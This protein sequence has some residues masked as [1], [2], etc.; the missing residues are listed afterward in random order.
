[1]VDTFDSYSAYD[2]PKAK[3]IQFV[4]KID[5]KFYFSNK[6]LL[7]VLVKKRILLAKKKHDEHFLDNLRNPGK[8]SHLLENEL[9][10]IFPSR[11]QWIRLNKRERRGKS[12]L[13]INAVSL[14]RTV[15]RKTRNFKEA[16][17]EDWYLKLIDFISEVRHMAMSNDYEIPEPKVVP[18][19]KKM[20]GEKKIYRPIAV[21]D[22][23]NKILISQ[24]NKY[25]TCCFD[26]VF[27]ENSYAFR[28]IKKGN[29]SYTHHL[30]VAD[31]IDYKRSNSNSEIWVS[32]CD[33]KKFYDVINHGIILKTLDE[34][35]ERCKK[36]N[37]HIENRPLSLLESYLNSYS[38]N[39]KVLKIKLPLN[40]EFGWV[41]ENELKDVDSNIYTDNIGIPQGG[42]FS[43]LI[44]NLIMDVVDRDVI[45]SGDQDLF[46][47]RF[48]DDMVI[49]HP[50]KEK[51]EAVLESYLHGLKK[52][53]LIG[54]PPVQIDKYSKQFWL[55][56]SKSPY[57][58]S[59]RANPK[60]VPWLSFV[61]YQISHN[62][63]IRVR[64]DSISKELRKQADEIGKVISLLNSRKSIKVSKSALKFRIKQ[65]LLTMS[66][67]RK[68][69]FNP[70]KP[71]VMCWTAGFK[72]LKV[73]NN[74][75]FQL[76]YL[77]RKRSSHFA[78][79]DRAIEIAPTSRFPKNKK[80][81]K[82]LENEPKFYGPPY[83]Y[84]YQ[85]KHYDR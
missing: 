22:L 10:E 71:G 27:C 79:L 21:F 68:S 43:C 14:E 5:F 32:E 3:G 28:S 25:L 37:I 42:A 65:R 23:K 83:S 48:C 8:D 16:I 54:H 38:F 75:D 40:S 46:Y 69:I 19:F 11:N 20:D 81:P 1:M 17:E 12:A 50:S 64:R 34:Q 4:M 67:G 72:I 26:Q 35:V 24:T 73:E 60:N 44:A 77:D 70:Q 9:Y 47:A 56:K 45:S 57:L 66:V 33:I 55:S 29:S 49:L 63:D 18:L 13:E 59:N 15:I 6:A 78:R 74:L 53:K 58:W 80:L 62:L 52:V 76:K 2:R 39:K 85:L 84:H 31:I 7:A 36:L 82:Q 41:K 61:G 30:A 51:C